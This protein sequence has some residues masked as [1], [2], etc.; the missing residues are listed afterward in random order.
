MGT[1]ALRRHQGLALILE[2]SPP[3]CLPTTSAR[4]RLDPGRTPANLSRP[5]FFL[6]VAGPGGALPLV[7]LQRPGP[8]IRVPA[9]ITGRVSPCVRRRPP[10]SATTCRGC[11]PPRVTFGGVVGRQ[12]YPCRTGSTG[13]DGGMVL[14]FR[15]CVRFRNFRALAVSPNGRR[16]DRHDSLITNLRFFRRV[17]RSR[18]HC[19]SGRS[20]LAAGRALYSGFEPA[21][22]RR[23]PDEARARGG[24]WLPRCLIGASPRFT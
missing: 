7:L 16:V 19:R 11:D 21:L 1:S 18:G 22:P 4:A 8:F 13:G 20:L 2:C 23:Q 12:I 10:A 14:V 15:P 9:V 24:P 3:S 5:R 6:L 17:L